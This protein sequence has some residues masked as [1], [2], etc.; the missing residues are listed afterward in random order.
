MGNGRTVLS[1]VLLIKLM[2]IEYLLVDLDHAETFLPEIEPQ[3]FGPV[4]K[5]RL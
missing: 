4:E 5:K 2:V 3:R 1:H